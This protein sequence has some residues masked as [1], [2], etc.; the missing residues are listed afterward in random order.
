MNF[1]SQDNNDFIV[2]PFIIIIIIIYYYYRHYKLEHKKDDDDDDD[3]DDVLPEYKETDITTYSPST[4]NNSNSE[5][6]DIVTLGN[7]N[8]HLPTYEETMANSNNN[9]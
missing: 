9:N 1:F 3:D 4:I 2:F 5:S 7:N 6:I 8:Y